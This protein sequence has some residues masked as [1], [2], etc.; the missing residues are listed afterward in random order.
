MAGQLLK[1][2]FHGPLLPQPTKVTVSSVDW[3]VDDLKKALI[4]EAPVLR[5]IGTPSL[6]VTCAKQVL[7]NVYISTGDGLPVDK[8][9]HLFGDLFSINSHFFIES[10]PATGSSSL[11]RVLGGIAC[12]P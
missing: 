9:L 6:I 11:Y 12:R 8:A 10:A 2:W 1:V 5:A 7:L 3:D 4:A